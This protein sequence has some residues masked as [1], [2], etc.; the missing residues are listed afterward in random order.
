V[1]PLP[2]SNAPSPSRSH[3]S[4]ASGP[5]GSDEVEVNTAVWPTRGAAL[6]VVKAAAG[7]RLPT[8][9]VCSA[10]ASAPSASRTRN[11]I[12]TDRSPA[13]N[14]REAVAPDPSSNPSPSVSHTCDA[15]GPSGSDAVERSCS[16]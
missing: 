7:R 3:A 4:A 8:V 11:R 15:S 12:R 14:T 16:V 13:R 6:L 10:V 9:T 5:S 1:T 2:S